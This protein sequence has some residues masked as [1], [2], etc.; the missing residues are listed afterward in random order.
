MRLIS[1]HFNNLTEYQCQQLS[2]LTGVGLT[3]VT[4]LGAH[5]LLQR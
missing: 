3:F 5:S 1:F 2:S 4:C